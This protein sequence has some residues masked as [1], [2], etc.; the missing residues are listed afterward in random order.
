MM[1]VYVVKVG[2][3]SVDERGCEIDEK[4]GISDPVFSA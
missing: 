4:S 3:C 2:C 1:S